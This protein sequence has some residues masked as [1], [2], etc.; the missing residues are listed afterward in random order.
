[1]NQ[2]ELI[3]KIYS[4][5]KFT[6]LL[7]D[8]EIFC[9]NGVEVYETEKSKI[10]LI[11]PNKIKI[12]LEDLA[13]I[14]N[15]SFLS[16]D[17]DGMW[18]FILKDKYSNKWKICSS[19]N[20]EYC[21]YYSTRSNIIISN[22]IFLV[23]YY[24]GLSELD[25]TSIGCFLS[26]ECV[27][28][29]FT[30]IKNIYKNF[31][32][33]IIYLYN[34]K[35]KIA[36]LN[37]E[38][39]F[40]FDNSIN[41]KNII[42]D[43]YFNSIKSFIQNRN[44]QVALTA[45]SDSRAVLAGVLHNTSDFKI[46]TGVSSTVSKRDIDISS[47]IAKNLV[48]EHIKTDASKQS[49]E[50]TTDEILYDV[51][52]QTS[53]E[54]MSSNWILYYLEYIK[55]FNFFENTSRLMG[56]ELLKPRSNYISLSLRKLNM[57]KKNY[58]DHIMDRI[59]TDYNNLF[60]ISNVY[61]DNLYDLRNKYPNWAGVNTRAYSQYYPIFNPLADIN[62][63]KLAFRFVGGFGALNFHENIYNFLPPNIKQIPINYPKVISK[64]LKFYRKYIYSPKDYNYHLKPEFLR[65]NL[66]LDLLNVI[67]PANQILKMISK[68]ESRGLYRVFLLNLNS[69]S[70]FHKILQTISD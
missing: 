30:F 36:K 47:R 4:L 38:K 61:V 66:N 45:G 49:T 21:W 37:L 58:K 20:N 10:W 64:L 29:G 68:Y 28:N 2:N 63:L 19:I 8:N 55:K 57:L 33:D 44:I 34:R 31:G 52:L 32:G 39:V 56:Y 54:Y 67:I 25:F 6:I 70:Y 12:N 9:A 23:S 7:K 60:S 5:D 1:M 16:T 11:N 3:N 14:D 43:T 13:K 24:S 59:I 18:A 41:N 62:T 46:F 35:F 40:Y 65:K 48:I 53:C 15:E 50:I 51:G 42:F 22:N 17:I 27:E 26:L 69:V